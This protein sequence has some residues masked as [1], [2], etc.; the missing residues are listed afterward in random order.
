MRRAICLGTLLTVA[1]FSLVA[2]GHQPPPPRGKIAAIQKVRDNLYFIRG[3]DPSAKA[4]ARDPQAVVTGGNVA[5]FVTE[6]GVV[7]VDTM[8]AGMGQQILEQIRSVTNKPVT[9]IINTHTHF[10]HSGSNIEFPPTVEFI[11]HENTKAYFSKATCSPVTN[12]ASFKGENAKFLPK[13]TFKDKMSLMS[14]KDRIDLY[15][16]GAGHT[17]GDALVVFPAVRAMHSGD[18]FGHKWVPYLFPEDGGSGI[19]YPQTLAKVIAGIPNVDT[20]IG[21]HSDLMTWA[22]L[23]EYQRF[24]MHFLAMVQAGVQGGRS[25]DQIAAEYKLPEIYKEYDLGTPARFKDEI[26]DIYNEL[27][28]ATQK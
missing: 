16:F 17:G 12:C 19:A 2:A 5:V 6:P 7:V 8:L 11:A 10:D 9:T 1:G 24:V 3:G 4:R 13:K 18:L 21:G 20:I 15:H 22:D 27:T 14:G 28:K 26:Q 25:V 23:Q